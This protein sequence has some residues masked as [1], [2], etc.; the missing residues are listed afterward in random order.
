[1]TVMMMMI[2]TA[3]KTKV[4]QLLHFLECNRGEEVLVYE[5]YKQK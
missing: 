1:M 5:R 2:I 4:T 3:T